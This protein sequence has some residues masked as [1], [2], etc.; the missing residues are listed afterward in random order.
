MDILQVV[1]QGGAVGVAAYTLYILKKLIGNH[2]DHN[3]KVL[4]N[5]TSVLTRLDQFLKDKIK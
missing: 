1:I 5:L 4:E 2:I 3:T